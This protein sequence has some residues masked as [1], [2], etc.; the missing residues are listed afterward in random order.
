VETVAPDTELLAPCIRLKQLTDYPNIHVLRLQFPA[1]DWEDGAYIDSERR[2]LVREALRTRLAGQFN[3]PVQWFY[4]PM[5]VTA[6]AGH[7]G[8]RATVYDCMDE[9]S[10]FKFAPPAIRDRER[11]LLQR[12][13]VVF[14]GGKRLFESKRQHHA[15]C[16]FYG[17]GVDVE[18]FGKATLEQTK[19]PPELSRMPKPVLGY[20]GV[21]DERIDYELLSKLAD[22]NPSWSVAMVGPVT[23]VDEALLPKRPNLHWLG[24]REYSDLPACA[25]GFDVC[26][27]PFAL[28]EA[29]EYINPTKSLEYMATG[30]TIVSSAVPD[31]VSNFGS[32]VNVAQTHDSFIALC[33][34]VAANPDRGKIERGLEMAAA[35]TWDSIVREL[36]SH[37]RAVLPKTAKRK[38]N[39]NTPIQHG[40]I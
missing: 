34:A 36:E 3:Q 5:A 18:H 12:A 32:V 6:F 15:N 8:E 17:C 2:R 23:K 24:R 9:L 39:L 30:R 20:F 31:V 22:A 14:T 16:H 26:L 25:K 10:Q 11:E 1:T 19:I 37:I 27:M 13:E 35:N 28:N 21:I 33:R 38:N 40:A 4:D 29:T 7:M